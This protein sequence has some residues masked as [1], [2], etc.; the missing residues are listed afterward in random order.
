MD[1]EILLSVS[2]ALRRETILFAPSSQSRFFVHVL[3][4]GGD[5]LMLLRCPTIYN[6]SQTELCQASL[7]TYAYPLETTVFLN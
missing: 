2:A 5:K 7:T 1:G 6:T 4:I 3:F